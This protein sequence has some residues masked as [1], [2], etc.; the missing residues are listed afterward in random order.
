[1]ILAKLL[2]ALG[3]LIDAIHD[4]WLMRND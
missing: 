1:M 4:W 3:N 2:E